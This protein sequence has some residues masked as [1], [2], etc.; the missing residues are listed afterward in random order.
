MFDSFLVVIPASCASGFDKKVER[1]THERPGHD[2]GERADRQIGIAD[3]LIGFP[4]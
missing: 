1:L 3:D 2:R 4:T